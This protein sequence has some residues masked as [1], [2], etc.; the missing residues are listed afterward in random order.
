VTPTAV[1]DADADA[2]ERRRRFLARR[3][4]IE[5]RARERARAI[6]DPGSFREL[7]GPFDR[8][9]SP[10]LPLQGIVPES[11]DGVV[12]ARGRLDGRAAVVLAIEG[13]FQGGSLGEVSATKLA[14]ALA[15]ARRDAERGQPVL[16]VLLLETGGVRL[17]EA[18]L[19][20]AIIAELHGEIVDLRRRIPVIGVIHGMLGCFGGMAIA[21][22]L[23]SYLVALRQGRLG[24]NGPEVTAQE[25][26]IGEL[27]PG[28]RRLL[29]ALMGGEQ[30]RDT[31]FV[32]ALTEDDVAAVR[33]A[34]CDLAGR[35]VPARHRSEEVDGYQRRLAAIDPAAPPDA[36]ALRQRWAGGDAP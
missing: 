29:W 16:P 21:A 13:A 11:D 23:C 27:D 5:L 31:G 8:L 22:G 2:A 7:L 26:G 12:V 1:D 6:L 4:I 17:Q 15:L 30:R 14:A 24:L 25:A 32:D 3:S 9:E 18:N 28:D 20:E 19:G 36:S 10:W 35:G 34:V 33:A